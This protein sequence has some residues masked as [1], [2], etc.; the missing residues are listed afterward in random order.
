MSCS[1]IALALAE[2]FS[3]AAFSMSTTA[4]GDAVEP[5]VAPGLP[6]WPSGSIGVG[7]TYRMRT[8]VAAGQGR[9]ATSRAA[10]SEGREPSI[11]S[12]IFMVAG[13]YATRTAPARE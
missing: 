5:I 3:A 7:T 12:K 4:A 9:V 1:A 11:A 8:T 2:A 13:M 10:I 6:A